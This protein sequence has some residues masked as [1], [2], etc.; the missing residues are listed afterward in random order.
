MSHGPVLSCDLG[1]GATGGDTASGGATG[2]DPGA[3]GGD[4]AT[5]GASAAAGAAGSS[6]T[7]GGYHESG[8]WHGYAWTA[9]DEAGQATVTPEDFEDL[10]VDG[11]YCASGNVPVTAD[12]MEFINDAVG[13]SYISDAMYLTAVMGGIEIWGAEWEPAS[14][15]SPPP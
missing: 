13:R 3:T 10:L 11:P 8:D 7:L 14:T 2:G 15:A 1:Y 9:V 6:G 5:G 4:T 12:Y